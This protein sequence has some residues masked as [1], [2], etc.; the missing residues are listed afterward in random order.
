MHTNYKYDKCLN[1]PHTDGSDYSGFAGIDFTFDSNT[2]TVDVPVPLTDDAIF[3]LTEQ[4]GASLAFP[5]APPPVVTLAPF[6]AQVTILD[7]DGKNT[8]YCIHVVYAY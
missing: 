2:S 1:S 6:A 3:E 5:G 8:A 4:F 7:D